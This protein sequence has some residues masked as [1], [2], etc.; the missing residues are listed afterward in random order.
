MTTNKENNN[1]ILGL[2]LLIFIIYAT[3]IFCL[4]PVAL[5]N[6]VL[7]ILLQ[8]GICLAIGVITGNRIWF[9]SAL[10]VLLISLGTCF[11]FV[12]IISKS[13]K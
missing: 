8:M 2:N 13:S 1:I 4:S 5:T 7:L 6:L 12:Y 9:L 10:L 11:A 3:I